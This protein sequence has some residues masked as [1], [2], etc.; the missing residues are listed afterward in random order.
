[1]IIDD[2]IIK[3][4]Y[5]DYH[6]FKEVDDA[7][8]NIDDEVDKSIKE[9]QNSFDDVEKTLDTIILLST[10]DNQYP[11]NKPILDYLTKWKEYRD[12]RVTSDNVFPVGSKQN[13]LFTLR[14]KAQYTNSIVKEIKMKYREF[15]NY[16][17]S[18]D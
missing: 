5:K 8:R 1:M 9:A 3:T 13:V 15:I 12:L 2:V 18:L 17:T 7:G 6:I 10:T 4:M 14:E 11:G 16:N